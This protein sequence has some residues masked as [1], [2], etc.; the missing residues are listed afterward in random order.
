MGLRPDPENDPVGVKNGAQSA[1]ESALDG[2][3][4]PEAGNPAPSARTA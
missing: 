4:A 1:P 2:R 3:R